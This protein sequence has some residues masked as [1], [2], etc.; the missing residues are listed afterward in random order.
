MV[1]P[2]DSGRV[3]D[4]RNTQNNISISSLSP[5]VIMI[6]IIIIGT[7]TMMRRLIA[8]TKTV[9]TTTTVN[10]KLMKGQW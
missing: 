2:Y 6:I 1:G 3:G 10:L 9:E 5:S 7:V 8:S 4:A